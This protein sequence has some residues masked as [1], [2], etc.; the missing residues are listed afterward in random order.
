MI[1]N[2]EEL[3]Q[4]VC[5]N[6]PLN[7]GGIIRTSCLNASKEEILE[8]INK[9]V[10]T[11]DDLIDVQFENYPSEIYNNGG[12]VKKYIIDNLDK[13]LAKITV[14]DKN[15]EKYVRNIVESEKVNIE[16]SIDDKF[17]EKFDFQRQLRKLENRKIW[18]DCGGFITIDKTEA[19]T[20]IDVN[21]G[22]FIGKSNFEDTIFTVNKEATIEIAKQLRARDI[23]TELLLLT[24]LIWI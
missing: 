12:I 22:K 8:D 17:L 23:R 5:D 6:L 18:L 1:K 20:A 19:L 7:T 3:K 2:K 16:F 9:L 10:K 13:G 15:V 24:I 14:S 21:S 11:W 4:F